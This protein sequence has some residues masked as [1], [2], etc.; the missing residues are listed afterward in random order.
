MFEGSF[1]YGD[2][3]HA[4]LRALD[5]LL[6]T[7]TEEDTPRMVYDAFAAG[8]PLLTSNIAFLQRRADRDKASVVFGIGAIDQGAAVLADLNADRAAFVRSFK[9]RYDC[10][11]SVMRSNDI[12]FLRC[13][14]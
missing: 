3:L 11:P 12:C 1:P 6:F 14:G 13:A 8:L 9:R 4:K 5:A 2:E 10:A 7:P